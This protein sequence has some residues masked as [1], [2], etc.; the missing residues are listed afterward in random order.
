MKNIR[1][2]SSCGCALPAEAAACPNCGEEFRNPST[3]NIPPEIPVSVP[4]PVAPAKLFC[5]RCGAPQ[6]E[7]NLFCPKCGAALAGVVKKSSER[8]HA[9]KTQQKAKSGLPQQSAGTT[10]HLQKITV[11]IVG[12]IGIVLI[13][14]AFYLNTGGGKT[15]QSSKQPVMPTGS[16]V[17]PMRLSETKKA[18]DASPDDPQ[19]MLSYANMLNDSK[20]FSEA[21]PYY[22]KYLET[23]PDNADARVDLGVCYFELKK[24]PA[25]IFEM[26]RAVKDQPGHQLGNFN[27]GVVNLQA[28]NQDKAREWFEKALKL[29]PSSETGLN[30]K[31]ILSEAF[32]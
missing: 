19:L 26:E 2:C 11:W 5:S 23:T 28:G 12:G 1:T 4:P 24:Y 13:A 22:R 18:L 20:Q 6:E 8:P 21:I 10:I 32:K 16:S 15:P 25:A 14:M 31:R 30:A 9:S 17:D 3:E 29:N 7:N 27:L